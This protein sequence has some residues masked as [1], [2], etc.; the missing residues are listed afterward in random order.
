MKLPFTCA[1]ILA[2][3][4]AV[5]AIAMPSEAGSYIRREETKA[6]V[7]E[8][9]FSV[10]DAVAFTHLTEP[11]EY[12]NA[13]PSIKRTPDRKK[14]YYATRRNDLNSNT[15]ESVLWTIEVPD[16][17]NYLA[18]NT[19]EKPKAKPL[20]RWK[21]SDQMENFG[22]MSRA[23]MIRDFRWAN[24]GTAVFFIG[25]EDNKPD[26]V[27]RVNIETGSVRQITHGD[28]PVVSYHLDWRHNRIFYY[29]LVP[30]ESDGKSRTAQLVGTND[31]KSIRSY[32]NEMLRRWTA[33]PQLAIQTIDSNLTATILP[34]PNG[35]SAE[36]YSSGIWPSPD[37]KLA[38]VAVVPPADRSWEG[39]YS[40]PESPEVANQP[41]VARHGFRYLGNAHRSYQQFYMLN[42]E[43]GRWWPILDA[44]AKGAA[45]AAWSSDGKT[46]V[47]GPTFLPVQS[48]SGVAEER[49]TWTYMVEYNVDSRSF[50]PIYTLA[51]DN[52]K[53]FAG[54]RHIDTE[55][56]SANQIRVRRYDGKELRHF[57][58]QRSSGDWV[59]S[60]DQDQKATNGAE[61]FVFQTLNIPPKIFARDLAT[62]VQKQIVE[63]N[64]QLEGVEYGKAEYIEWPDQSGGVWRGVL[65]YPVNYQKSKRYPLV[66]QN[67]GVNP[68][69]FLVG[70]HE[71]ATAPFAARPLA[72]KG[73]FVL[74]TSP[75]AMS[76]QGEVKM[77][78]MLDNA[79]RG[80]EAAIDNLDRKGLIDPGKVGLTGWSLTGLPVL[81][82]VTFSSKRIAA[83][84]IADAYGAGMYM[85]ASE[86]GYAPPGMH[87]PETLY[88]NSY[89]WG[90]GLSQW[91]KNN[92]VFNLD[93]VRTPLLIQNYLPEVELQWWEVYAILR[94]LGKPV[95]MWNYPGSE[96]SP[97]RPDQQRHA[98]QMIV[99]WYAFWLKGEKNDAVRNSEQ[100]SR[101]EEEKRLYML[102]SKMMPSRSGE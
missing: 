25:K 59:I 39:A 89:P 20:V 83:A 14:F 28:Y 44:P 13:A 101:W 38:V 79:N 36:R 34:F 32:Q 43:E 5:G 56:L 3:Y 53:E 76:G 49:R 67:R 86:F 97:R 19:K 65:V 62:E 69:E 30:D 17:E 93:K 35:V 61:L 58:L 52:E 4:A 8:S 45:S 77:E 33:R 64:P 96:H 68:N 102:N 88:R 31:L 60:N 81:N 18:G 46:V 57:T 51:G 54:I 84:V 1:L 85:Y 23:G 21:T 22:L 11:Y 10:R 66:I 55:V 24:D 37:G 27:Y 40:R 72:S 42:L 75:R 99:D 74:Q 70:G 29:R 98:Q 78:A 15:T 16:V 2:G 41:D 6:R 92:P 100:Y 82:T 80:I 73:M 26:Q 47:F 7:Q 95:E 87:Y 63:L 90:N 12:L 50:R 9:L 91:V 48:D 71:G 94:R